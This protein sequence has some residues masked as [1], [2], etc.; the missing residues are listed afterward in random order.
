MPICCAEGFFL[1][2]A[3]CP[4][5]IANPP[6][7]LISEQKGV[8]RGKYDGV[9]PCSVR[10]LEKWIQNHVRFDVEHAAK[11][12][13]PGGILLA[14]CPSIVQV[15]QLREKLAEGNFDMPETLE[16]LNRTWHVEGLAVRPD[17]RMVA[18]TGFLTHARLLGE[19]Q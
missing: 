19:R 12:L 15:M 17:H 2:E 18:H 3:T 10:E 13:H 6:A 9:K 11:A 8:T 16:V 5:F 7:G 4:T 1:W 14:Y